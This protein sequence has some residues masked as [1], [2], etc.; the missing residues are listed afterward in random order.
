[1]ISDTCPVPPG[2]GPIPRDGLEIIGN[3]SGTGSIP[4]DGSEI[5][6]KKGKLC[7]PMI[8]D[9]SLGIVP[10][11]GG[12]GHGDTDGPEKVSKTTKQASSLVPILLPTHHYGFNGSCL[13]RKN[14]GNWNTLKMKTRLMDE[15]FASVMGECEI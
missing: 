8:S 6:G 10:V 4:R 12:T 1:M 9:P 15:K 2:T 11:P 3:Q 7:F 5:I 13:L 14:K